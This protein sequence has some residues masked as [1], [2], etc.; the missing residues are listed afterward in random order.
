MIKIVTLLFLSTLFGEMLS[1]TNGKSLNYTHVLFEWRQV[2]DAVSYELQISTDEIFN[3]RI[4]SVNTDKLIYI[5]I[6]NINW[7]STYHWRVRAIYED[8]SISDWFNEHTFTTLN[9]ITSTDILL[10]DSEKYQE[11]ITFLG[12]YTPIELDGS[13]YKFTAAFDKNGDEIW[14]TQDNNIIIYNTNMMGEFY[15]CYFNE[16]QENEY[17]PI[18]FN[19]DTEVVWFGPTE[20]GSDHDLIQLPDGNYLSIV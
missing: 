1:P 19:L 4:H 20:K 17:P 5:D 16:G 10:Y 6:D 3:T 12:S 18:E 9:P 11:G 8:D 15:G 7:Q 14:N 13:S 2:P